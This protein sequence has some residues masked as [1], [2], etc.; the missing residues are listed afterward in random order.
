MDT[1]N[2]AMEK[3]KFS[4]NY[5][6]ELS[7]GTNNKGLSKI[8]DMLADEESKHYKT[9]EQL[10]KNT[11][12]GTFARHLIL[13]IRSANWLSRRGIILTFTLRGGK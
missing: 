11:S 2:F 8:F 4:E 7:V 13:P 3:E 9:V 5:Y 1:F 10:K 6:R 12:S